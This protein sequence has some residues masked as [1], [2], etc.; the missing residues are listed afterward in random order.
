MNI[1]NELKTFWF[2][3]FEK[4]ARW[5]IEQESDY[6]KNI[7]KVNNEIIG[8]ICLNAPRGAVTFTAKA[9]RIDELKD[10]SINIIDYKTGKIPSKNQVYAGH[11]L[12]LVLEGLIAK[13]GK[14]DNIPNK[15]LDKLTYWQL[16]TKSLD[17][18]PD[19]DDIIDKTEEYLMRLI[20]AF[21]FETTFNC[22]S[23]S[24]MCF[25]L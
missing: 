5:I 3:K 17:L 10:N 7:K 15:Q 12:Q 21:D 18:N 4:I 14:F 22:F 19:E 16:G 13:K 9:D 8:Q 11:A 23:F 20:S 24:N 25:G 2:P 6:R 1:E